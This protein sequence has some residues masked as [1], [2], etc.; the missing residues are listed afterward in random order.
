MSDDKNGTPTDEALE[1][2]Q[3]DAVVKTQESEE[4][5][6]N[7]IDVEQELNN[8]KAEIGRGGK[9]LNEVASL[10]ED[11]ASLKAIIENQADQR[12]TEEAR[13]NIVTTEEDVAKVF[14][15][16]QQNQQTALKKYED[17]YWGN[18][19]KFTLDEELSD[20]DVNELEEVLKTSVKG[21]ETNYTNSAIDAKMNYLKAKL[22]LQSKG[23]KLNLKGDNPKATGVDSP[24]KQDTK[25]VELPSNMNADETAMV[26][27]LR[28][29]GMKDEEIAKKLQ[30]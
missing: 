1:K 6:E 12:Q 5:Q 13:E 17:S 7:K 2:A 20:E 25:T 14:N 24:S 27:W 8:L 16:M 21:S 18:I 19:A 11:I 30:G 29:K 3:D 26:D 23:K 15:K 9:A 4:S 22:V 10:K 28:G